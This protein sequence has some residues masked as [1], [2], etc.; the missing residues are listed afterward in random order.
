MIKTLPAIKL[1]ISYETGEPGKATAILH[2]EIEVEA[3]QCYRLY[4]Q[5]SRWRCVKVETKSGPG[6]T[7]VKMAYLTEVLF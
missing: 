7:P 5:E 1:D 3:D 2:P 4:N 6:R